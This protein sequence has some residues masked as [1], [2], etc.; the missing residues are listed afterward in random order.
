MPAHEDA[1]R[2]PSVAWRRKVPVRYECDVAVIGG[3]MAGVSAAFAAARSGAKVILVEGYGVLGGN[4]TIGGVGSFC[5]ETAGQGEAFDAIVEGLQAFGA[6]EAYRPYPEADHRIFAPEILEVVLQE[7]ALRRG[8]K[9]LLHTQCMDVCVKNE[10]INECILCG[11]SG[12][13]A[14]RARL[15]VDA[16]GEAVVARQAG[17]ETVKG[18]PADG[19][20]LP[21]SL[22][23]FVRE[24]HGAAA[25]PEVPEGWF[26]PIRSLD[27]LPMTSV[28]PNGAGGKAI[29]VKVPKFDAGDTESL[30]AAE[31]HARR[32][33]MSVLDYYQR[34]E[35]KPWRLDHCSP[36]IGIR[37]GRRVVGEYVLKLEDLR[38]GR[39]FED[40]VARG[41]YY[42]DGHKP[43]DEKRTYIL[44]PEERVVPPYQ[45]PLRSLIPRGSK[46][47]LVAGRCFSADQLALSSARVM[48]SCSM[49]GQAAGITA[50][51]AAGGRCDISHVDAAEVRRIVCERGA[52][53]SV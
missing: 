44:P 42:L 21:M 28:W 29:K 17:F 50:A 26:D 34:V 2:G 11:S 18:R 25:S 31:I 13:E 14:L 32:R 47:L 52:N 45:I 41:V 36:R 43:D 9:L 24:T 4:G 30:T 3:G 39:Q 38:A 35:G 49:M 40:A 37:E 46:N 6:I 19:L 22:M 53:L 23:F 8:I 7:L 15:Y 16:T 51:L 1:E 12:P 27:A 20:T 10:R 33:M 48:T 5:G